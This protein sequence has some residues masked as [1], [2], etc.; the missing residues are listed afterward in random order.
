MSRLFVMLLI[1]LSDLAWAQLPAVVWAGGTGD[2][3]MDNGQVI[4]LD[5]AGN[6]VMTGYFTSPVITFGSTTLTN[7]DSLG[8]ADFFVAKY[9]SSGS[10]LWAQRIGGSS[11]E[12]GYGVATDAAGN[13]V[14]SGSF[15][16]ATITLGNITLF[17][18]N[19]AGTSS[20]IFFAKYDA[21][22]NVLWAKSS[23][24]INW[25]NGS[26]VATDKFG[27]VFVTGYYASSQ[28]TFGA[29][30]LNNSGIYDVFL[31]KY[32]AGGNFLWARSSVGSGSDIGN[33][34]AVDPN[35]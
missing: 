30:T 12:Y 5:A 7:A 22:G 21:A 26:Q 13:I 2:V 6:I 20:D 8:T 10:V 11:N 18:A 31:A 3:G 25:D 14:V 1:L 9:S 27:N 35:G 34:V 28:I 19:P 23:G 33:N 24:G 17:N 4:A 29:T 16:S 32:D 15:T